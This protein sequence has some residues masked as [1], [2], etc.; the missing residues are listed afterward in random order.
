MNLKRAGQGVVDGIVAEDIGKF[1]D[2]NLAESLQRI[3]GVSINRTA[4]GE[5]QQ[6][7]VRG[8]GP[9]F[10]LVLLNG[11]QMPA[12]N[13]G[14]GGAGVTNSRAYDFSNLASEAVSAIEV[15]KTARAESPTGGIGATINIQTA[16]PLDKPGLVANFGVKGVYDPSATNLP[17]NSSGSE[18]T[19]EVSA[20]FSN[21]FADDR[22][23]IAA[24]ASYQERDSGFSQAAVANG[25]KT[26]SGAN[27]TDGARLPRPGDPNYP[28]Y[29]I[30]NAPEVTD[31][32]GRPQ[33]FGLSVNGV[34]RERVNGQL[35]LQFAPTDSL[36]TTLDY[37]Y[38]ENKV[39]TQR[40]ELS[41]WFNWGPGT[42]SWTDGPAAG[43]EVYSE[44]MT[45]SDLSMGG[46]NLGTKNENTSLGFNVA[47][48]VNDSLSLELD[49]HDSVAESE[50]DSPY[51][52][53]GVLGVAAFIRGTTT[54]DFSGDF[55]I[56]NVVLPTGRTQVEP[57]DALVTGS[58]F[59]NS[60]NRSD[61][62]QIQAKGHFEFQNN[63]GLDFGVSATE[64]QNR[65]AAAVMQQ[66]N[67]GGLGAAADYD[68]DIWFGDDMGGYFDL[69]SGHDD[70]R[71]TDHFL[72]FD[73]NRLRA[74]AAEV[75]GDEAMFRAPDEF[76]SDLRSVEKSKSAY[77]QYSKTFET[78]M[79]FHVA[80]GVRY[81]ETEVESESLVRI[82]QTIS[83][84]S[85]N[86]FN[87]GFAPE[88]GFDAGT[89]KYDYVLPSLDLKLDIKENLM[90]RASYSETIGRPGWNDI[91]GGANLAGQLR[92]D[93]GTGSSG[94]PG[95]KPL[96]S[97]N[98][99]LS[100]EWYYGPASYVSV[101]YFRKEISNFI[102]N[103]ITTE[104]PFEMHT[105]AGGAL[106]NEAVASGCNAG[107]RP[108]I[109]NYIFANHPTAP[110]VTVGAAPGTGTIVGQPG[111]PI[112]TFLMSRPANQRSDELD[113]W[114]I[115]LQHM[116]GDSGFG[117]AANYTMVESGLEFNDTDLVNP[118]YPMLGLA[119]SYNLVAF[120][121]KFGWQV[122]AA[123]NWRDEFLAFVGDG[124][125]V[126]PGYTDAYGQLD[127]NVTYSV[128]DH[129]SVFGE[130]IN[131]TEE[132][133]R[134]HGRN[135]NQLLFATQIG[136][137][138][139]FGARYKF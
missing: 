24:S 1:P 26:L 129:L 88:Q 70:S 65:T 95:L 79:P 14:P 30:T 80:A 15:F 58:V 106:W 33:N 98:Y 53:A 35:V 42:S 99:D 108:C 89:G 10:N 76:T 97:T 116:L 52:S 131:L 17:S 29:A 27:T 104:T 137:R 66:N 109:R 72:V 41:V 63:S 3:S 83:W 5:G 59:Q 44:T 43:P 2:T 34:Q 32:Y 85:A 50:P 12:S 87:I 11:R 18:L 139:Q 94:D 123:Y 105:P 93:G 111:D 37:T 4:S 28:G 133:Q 132:T 67:W 119:D 75:L 124:Q 110:G 60:F 20:I 25:W 48:E 107:D 134:I 135:D 86:E 136:A 23:G 54:V 100:L 62:Q 68:D 122:R 21:T 31:V 45:G 138:Y 128:N 47:W 61:V 121:D 96:E 8:V 84:D 78:A 101:G 92:F 73:F 102:S 90:L 91:Q 74:Q 55:P 56:L 103:V 130:A 51:G 69:M 9:D 7:T 36:T 113:G 115:N 64:V 46:M 6:V 22:F 71:F 127:F 81:E 112:A 49:Y 118:Q 77:L 125:G 16:R 40:S 57:A 13:L 117:L 120:F 38:A 19:P 39:Q 82:G 114:E 126:N